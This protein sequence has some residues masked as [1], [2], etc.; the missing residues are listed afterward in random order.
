MAEERERSLVRGG[1]VHE[2]AVEITD[3]DLHLRAEAGRVL[4]DK[5]A[6]A[7]GF[8]GVFAEDG[9][10]VRGRQLLQLDDRFLRFGLETLQ[11]A[12]R[13]IEMRNSLSADESWVG[14]R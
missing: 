4:V 12:N 3:R 7:L 5:F 11:R 2:P 8:A 6:K 13:K 9:D 10:V 14:R 1:L